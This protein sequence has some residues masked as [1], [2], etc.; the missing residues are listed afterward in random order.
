MNSYVHNFK[1]STKADI[2]RVGGKGANLIELSKIKGINVPEGFCI[3]TE[4][5]KK[6][7]ENNAR[8]N[9][10]LDQLS[11]LK[12]NEKDKIKTISDQIHGVIENTIIPEEITEAITAELRILGE[13]H[14]YAVRSSATAEDLPTASFAGQHDTYL[15]II[16]K[17]SI[18]K[19]I[20]TCWASLYTERAVTYRIQN[21][22]DH[23]KVF[24]AVIIQRM[25]IPKSSGIMFT[26]DPV[27]SNRKVTSI[28]A[29][30]G[31]GEAVVS[32]LVNPDIYKV[33][34]R[35][36]INKNIA[37]KNIAIY[38]LED[39]GTEERKIDSD[40]IN[41]QTLTDEQILRLEQ[42]GRQI[43]TYFACPQDIEWCLLENE[44]YIVQSRPITTLYPIPKVTDG[45][46]RVFLS[47]GHMQMMTDPIKPL[48]M[49]FFK[50]VLG[51]PPSQEIGGR[52]YVDITYDLATLLGRLIA[53]SIIG[54]IGDT[55]ITNS[56]INIIKD[57]KLIRT[58]P[59]GKDRV[60]K[61]ENNSGALSI[62]VNAYKIY[63]K[64]DPDI[65]KS[66]ISKEDDSIEKMNKEIEKLSGDE[67]FDYIYKDHDNRRQKLTMP[68]SAGALTAVLLSEKWFNRKIKKWLGIKNAADTF[69][70]S[71]PNSV[72][73]DTGL[74]LLDVA[75]VVRQ[76][77]AVLDY[78]DHA[79]DETFFED[80][81]G[82]EGGDA[83]CNSIRDYLE[84]YGMRCSGD[85]D[86]TKPR[87][88]EQPTLLIPMILSNIKNFEP[89]SRSVKYEQ[90]RLE[91]EQNIQDIAD[92]LKKLPGGK[93][94][95]VKAK[96][97][98]GII[99]NYIGY[100]EYPKF[101]Y[102]KRYYMYKQAMLKEAAKLLS[103]GIIKEIEDVYYLHFDEFR[104]AVNTGRLDYSIIESRKKDYKGYEK[105]T[106]PRVMT[107]DGEIITGEYDTADMPEDALPGIAVSAG[108]IEG[109]AKVVSRFEE[110]E[111]EDGDILVTQFTD[112]SWTP[113]FVSIKGLV[114]EVGGLI[115]H[116]AIIAREY[117]LP[118]VVSVENAT[119]LIKDGQMI[120][121]NGTEGY[122]QILS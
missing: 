16:G 70:M 29:S 17:D 15:N 6:A 52:L 47:S 3:T 31:L 14:S 61:P 48:G 79:E 82:I 118:A 122:I 19:H 107:S 75:D 45:E 120:R 65:I 44:L 76:Y 115:T 13:N 7:F 55:L 33:R 98:A 64:N 24:L 94:K 68:R 51:G 67:L 80:V 53:K 18:L 5:Y 71:I 40:L 43:E 54:M 114:T 90:G 57:K 50:S 109:R 91:S 92:R 74:A 78:F 8:L 101:A 88:S 25:V 30:Y 27:T 73:S 39:G 87:W 34:D 20:S 69:L 32:G 110:A 116:G 21:N 41:K 81:A 96:R 46:H 22:F 99:R 84:K 2:S 62:M 49:D 63:K 60:F 4:A 77:P 10:L 66:L 112:P 11:L 86:I 97:I 83:V 23:R 72:T 93:R 100:R 121:V 104:N 35:A 105:L 26:A 28:D 102:I 117:G 1:E 95:A 59:K 111:L 12:R 42:M 37:A 9:S 106:P 119:Q 56:I 85:I 108:I 36:I 103:K 113:L 89:D 58:L 38:A